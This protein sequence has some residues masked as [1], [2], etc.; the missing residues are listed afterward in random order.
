MSRGGPE[1][2]TEAAREELA[3]LAPGGGLILAA[4]CALPPDTPAENIHA[5][6]EAAKTLGRYDPDGSLP[7]LA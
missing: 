3:I 5:L 1:D 2:V 7:G 4:G 6:I